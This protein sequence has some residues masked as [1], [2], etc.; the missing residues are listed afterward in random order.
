MAEMD[1]VEL[2]GATLQQVAGGAEYFCGDRELPPCYN[3]QVQWFS[4][5]FIGA[6][7]K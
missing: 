4:E 7:T 2:D 5:T 3:F 1:D 6:V